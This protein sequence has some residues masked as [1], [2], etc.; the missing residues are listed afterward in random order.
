MFLVEDAPERSFVSTATNHF[1]WRD[2]EKILGEDHWI[3]S[4]KDSAIRCFG[5]LAAYHAGAEFVLTL[6]DDCYPDGRGSEPFMNQHVGWMLTRTRWTSSVP[7]F[8]ARGY[9]K[10][11]LGTLPNVV[12]NV[13]LWTGVPDQSAES[14]LACPLT[15]FRPPRGSRVIPAGQ[16]VP[17]SGMNLCIRRDAIPL[18]YFP[19]M[20]QGSPYS[21]FDDIWA[22]VI[23]K[24][25]CDHLGWHFTVGEPFV[26]HRRA[27]DPQVNL[28]K[29]A[30]GVEVN[31]IFWQVID[32]IFLAP[33]DALGA[34][35]EM[36][37]VLAGGGSLGLGGPT[38]YF[39]RLGEALQVWA[40]L[41][42]VRPPGL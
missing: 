25:V 42:T 37:R 27:S 11:N 33:G 20:G 41:L 36:G 5:L 31:E 34:V 22:G 24:K 2:I 3:I 8:I 32:R 18:F 38:L 13:G 30:P 12:A 29:E 40:R 21:R 16:Y 26:N 15:D 4:R 23:A 39:K 10:R 9:P 6:D 1:A 35:C 17:V 7:G 19:L 14:Q 28:A